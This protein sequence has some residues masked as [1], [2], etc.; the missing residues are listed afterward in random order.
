MNICNFDLIILIILMFIV[1]FFYDIIKKYFNVKEGFDLLSDAKTAVN[2]LYNADIEAIRNLSSIAAK[3]QT[4]GLTVPGNLIADKL[5]VKGGNDAPA[6]WMT[7]FPFND[8]I[9]YIRGNTNQDGQ[10]TVNGNSI[11]NGNLTVTG[12]INI[13]GKIKIGN[14]EINTNDLIFNNKN[15]PQVTINSGGISF[16]NNTN[17][18]NGVSS[19]IGN[20][21][22]QLYIYRFENRP[23]DKS[24]DGSAYNYVAFFID[25]TGRIQQGPYPSGWRYIAG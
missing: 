6:G 10:L 20:N 14:I 4:N 25:Q 1:N 23:N 7:H 16:K 8:G 21:N 24:P 9:N 3:L 22:G 13:T 19:V 5:W 2:Q 18:P 12:D 11:V 15:I 17:D